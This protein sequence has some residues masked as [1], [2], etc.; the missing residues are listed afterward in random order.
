[1][2]AT[3]HTCFQRQAPVVNDGTDS[4]LTVAGAAA[5]SQR[6]TDA[7]LLRSLFIPMKGTI[8][9]QGYLLARWPSTTCQPGAE[10]NPLNDVRQVFPGSTCKDR[11]RVTVAPT[12]PTIA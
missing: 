12:P 9:A 8:S 6:H 11:Y 2:P 1:M 10:M 3:H 5:D 7:A 4:P